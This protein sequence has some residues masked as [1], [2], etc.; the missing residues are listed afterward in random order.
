MLKRKDNEN[1]QFEDM[2]KMI[3]MKKGWTQVSIGN[4][5]PEVPGEKK[6]QKELP[7]CPK[8][9]SSALFMQINIF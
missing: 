6:N 5:K 3:W 9:I 4:D 7:D 2:K 1:N 8:L